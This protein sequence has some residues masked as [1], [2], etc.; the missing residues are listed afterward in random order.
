M[1]FVCYSEYGEMTRGCVV[2][3][4]LACMELH[5]LALYDMAHNRMLVIVPKTRDSWN[6]GSLSG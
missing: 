5:G 3:I 1:L 2:S 4:V 6:M